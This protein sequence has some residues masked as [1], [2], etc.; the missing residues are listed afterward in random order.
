MKLE[1][2]TTSTFEQPLPKWLKQRLVHAQQEHEDIPMTES[3]FRRML[4]R[5]YRNS[6]KIYSP[7][8]ILRKGAVLRVIAGKIVK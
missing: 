3:T 1:E 8:D 4:A 5:I 7:L 2:A 6:G